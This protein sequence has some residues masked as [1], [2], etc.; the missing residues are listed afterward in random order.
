M[1]NFAYDAQ[2]RRFLIQFI[3]IMSHFQVEFGKDRDGNASLQQVPVFYGDSSTQVAQIL[4]GN[5]ENAMPSVPAIACYIGALDYDRARVQQPYHVS[6][7]NIRERN[8]DA[9]TDTFGSSQGDAFTVER[10][11]PVPYKLTLKVDIWTSN[12]EQKLQLI[13]QMLPLFNPAMEI[14]STDN[15]IDWTSLSAVF[16]TNTSWSS[17]QVPM[18]ANVQ[19]DVASLTFELPIWLSLPAK[20]KRLGVIQRIIASIYEV[21]GQLDG[22]ILDLPNAAILSTQVFTPTGFGVIYV[23]NTM[24]LYKAYLKGDTPS[25]DPLA[26]AADSPYAWSEFVESYGRDIQNG[27]TQIR[28]F[29]PN[30]T[31]VMGTVAYHPVDST[32]LIFSPILDTH[33]GNTILP[34]NAII[35]PYNM[36]VDPTYLQ[37]VTGTRYL[38]LNPIGSVINDGSIQGPGDGIGG[39]AGIAW[40]GTDGNN[41]IA[42]A[43]DIIEFNGASWFVSFAAAAE[44]GVKYMTNLKTGLQFKWIPETQSWSKAV[45]G[46]YDAGDWTIVFS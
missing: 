12:T 3:R 38:I 13:E 8:Y 19:I 35:D 25:Y 27:I 34:V 18:G 45:E 1:N 36:P 22:D 5:T 39:T 17:R 4:Q 31:E 9:L 11:M 43:N 23:G 29:Q 46:R 10:P 30:G 44:T 28:L 6:K 16:L 41:L 24:Q 7:L 2:I 32:L 21:S 14:Q 37:A 42:E 15:Y 26:T 40:H 33:P 20:V